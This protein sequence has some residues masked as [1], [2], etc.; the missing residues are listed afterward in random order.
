M[1]IEETVTPFRRIILIAIVGGIIAGLGA[2]F[3]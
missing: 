2:L 1:Q 3:F